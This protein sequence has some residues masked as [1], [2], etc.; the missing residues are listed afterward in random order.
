MGL[1]IVQEL[2]SV[3]WSR[4][5]TTLGHNTKTFFTTVVVL[6]VVVVVVVDVVEVVVVY[7]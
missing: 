6:E 5:G 2:S 3:S 1:Q 4:S 7:K